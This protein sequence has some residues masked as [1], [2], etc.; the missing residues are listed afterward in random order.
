MAATSSP[1]IVRVKNVV[2]LREHTL[3]AGEDLWFRRCA[4]GTN[5]RPSEVID[6]QDAFWRAQREARP[7]AA[8]VVI[9]GGGSICCPGYIDL[10]L[11][12]AFGVDFTNGALTEEGTRRVAQ[13]IL[14]HGVTSF[15]PTVITSAKAT[16]HAVLPVLRS[17]QHADRSSTGANILGLHLEGPFISPH[18][19]GA[20]EPAYI[21]PEVRSLQ[22]IYDM[23]GVENMP[24][25]RLITLAPELPGALAAIEGLTAAGVMVSIGHSRATIEEG[26]LACQNGARKITHLFNAMS[27]FHHRDPGLLGLLGLSKRRNVHYG[28]IPDGFHAHPAAVKIAYDAH[29]SGASWL[30]MPCAPWACPRASTS[31][32]RRR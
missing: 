16:Y 17:V 2:L 25:V 9:D 30:R 8:D 29:P 23:Y 4:P 21:C 12:G 24:D 15:L 7:F 1:C 20:H 22:S 31:L 27:S 26:A 5:D 3:V 18:K 19:K 10:Q 14:A 6:A 32:E 11:N 28:I 13:G